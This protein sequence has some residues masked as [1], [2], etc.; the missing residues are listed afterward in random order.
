[1]HWYVLSCVLMACW[2]FVFAIGAPGWPLWYA[3]GAAG[4]LALVML[5]VFRV[6]VAGPESAES[7]EG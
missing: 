6:V 7:N 1:M 5:T 4:L 2:L 3:V